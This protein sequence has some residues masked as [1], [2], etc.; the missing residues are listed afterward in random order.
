MEDELD[1]DP[2]G[3][4]LGTDEYDGDGSD[5]I[6]P[7]DAVD[8]VDG[9]IARFEMSTLKTPPDELSG[10]SKLTRC[11]SVN[12]GTSRGVTCSV[13]SAGQ[14]N[15]SRCYH[16]L[17]TEPGYI[18]AR[19]RGIAVEPHLSHDANHIRRDNLICDRTGEREEDCRGDSLVTCE[20]NPV[21]LL[22]QVYCN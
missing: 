14:K 7:A 18:A 9:G 2:D 5:V 13:S 15:S 19:K 12:N 1:K 4:Y 11:Q 8:T 3:V 10:V 16:L 22:D 21:Q 20:P 17:R 6:E